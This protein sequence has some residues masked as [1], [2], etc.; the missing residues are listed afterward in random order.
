VGIDKT[1]MRLTAA[2]SAKGWL[3]D[4]PS[5]ELTKSAQVLQRMHL[6][7][8]V[9]QAFHDGQGQPLPWQITTLVA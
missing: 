3:V 2:P 6:S 1:S 4:V 9:L 8:H 5:I 7:C